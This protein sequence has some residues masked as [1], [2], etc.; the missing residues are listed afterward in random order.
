MTEPLPEN[1][2]RAGYD[3]LEELINRMLRGA[4]SLSKHAMRLRLNE[5]KSHRDAI[6]QLRR[7]QAFKMPCSEEVAVIEGALTGLTEPESRAL[8]ERR[9]VERNR[10]ERA[11][12]NVSDKHLEEQLQQGGWLRRETVRT[13]TSRAA[14]LS[15]AASHVEKNAGSVDLAKTLVCCLDVEMAAGDPFCVLASQL[16]QIDGHREE[17][18]S[19]GDNVV[20]G[21]WDTAG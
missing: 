15:Q 7:Y 17:V 4:T 10:L 20:A 2:R 14:L 8:S 21:P 5:P 16:R 13:A 12:R 11:A 1:I 3:A 19:V 18:A 9:R 6:A